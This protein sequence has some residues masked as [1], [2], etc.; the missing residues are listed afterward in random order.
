MSEFFSVL[1]TFLFTLIFVL[2]M[3]MQ[4]GGVTLENRFEDWIQ[5]SAATSQFQKA[6]AGAG[7]WCQNNYRWMENKIKG[8]WRENISQR[9]LS[10][11]VQSEQKASR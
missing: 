8:L 11:D 3:Q 9:P 5:N 4:L 2:L 10:Q 6:A 1:K 7:L